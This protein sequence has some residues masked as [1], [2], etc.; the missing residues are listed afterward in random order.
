[1]NLYPV[2]LVTGAAA[3]YLAWAVLD[4]GRAL[5]ATRLVALSYPAS[6]GGG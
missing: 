4:P 1:M 6:A 3:Q 5:P 2:T